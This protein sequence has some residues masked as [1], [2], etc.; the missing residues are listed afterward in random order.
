M[1]AGEAGCGT[2]ASRGIM[3]DSAVPQGHGFPLILQG[4]IIIRHL[5]G[6]NH[7]MGTA[8]TG[9]TVEPAMT[10]GV[11]VERCP[12]IHLGYP[13]AGGAG[14]MAVDTLGLAG[15]GD[16]GARGSS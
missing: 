15:P 9:G 13:R 3:A 6:R 4:L 8:V 12:R 7:G 11:T 10:A 2:A 1:L 14:D 5:V 16:A